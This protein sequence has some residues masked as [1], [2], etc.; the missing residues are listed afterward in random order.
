[1][2]PGIEVN[3]SDEGEK[4]PSVFLGLKAGV[5]GPSP[6][7]ASGD[8][9]DRPGWED[10]IPDVSPQNPSRG[11][12]DTAKRRDKE[13]RSLPDSHRHSLA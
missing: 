2:E 7:S 6:H 11:S 9:R 12:A 13:A 8:R 1:V 10:I 5:P 3:K 4:G